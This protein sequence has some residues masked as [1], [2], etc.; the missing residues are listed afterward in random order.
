MHV[1]RSTW[2]LFVLLAASWGSSFF[3]TLLALRSFSPALLV[4]VRLAIAALV[5]GAVVGLSRTRLPRRARDY[6]KLCGLALVNVTVPF[7]LLTWGQQ[8]VNTSLTAVLS[9]AT[10]LLVF[11]I[12]SVTE[13]DERFSWLRLLGTLTAFAGIAVLSYGTAADPSGTFSTI[14]VLAILGS[15]VVFAA[16]NVLS[17]RITR[18]QPALVVAFVQSVASCLL[19]IPLVTLTGDWHYHP[20]GW[21]PIVAMLWLGIVGSALTYVIYFHLIR[22][23]GSTRTSLN[24]YLQPIVGVG[25]GVLVLG[26]AISTQ[27][28]MA[29][30]VV[31]CGVA[32]FLWGTAR[33]SRGD[34]LVRRPAAGVASNDRSAPAGFPAGRRAS[35]P[36]HSSTECDGAS[37]RRSQIRY[38]V[39]NDRPREAGGSDRV[40]IIVQRAFGPFR[41]GRRGA[42]EAAGCDPVRGISSEPPVD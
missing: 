40:S 19:E 15:S 18:T 37:R 7:T 34:R 27:T 25:L 6:L 29:M 22:V 28:L 26:E 23:W 20:A 9:S 38:L 32:L 1:G 16:G 4:A 35:V 13:R 8:F 2:L 36:G 30:G 41:H 11:A 42:R 21:E 14:G 12:T 3:W 17:R 5:L 33:Q 31:G 10:P 39:Y 24:T